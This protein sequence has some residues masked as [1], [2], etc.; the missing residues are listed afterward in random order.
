MKNPCTGLCRF[1][2]GTGWC[3]GCGRSRADCRDWK[4]RPETRPGI[5]RLPV[6]ARRD[7]LLL[8]PRVGRDGMVRVY[9]SRPDGAREL[10][11]ALQNTGENWTPV[12]ARYELVVPPWL[13]DRET[14]LEIEL[15]G[16]WAQL[17][18]LGDAALF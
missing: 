15:T 6:T 10:L 13:R 2:S 5:L 8:F 3:K 16:R 14:D 17:W 1:D 9:G 4:R 12:S 7:R 11:F 18:T